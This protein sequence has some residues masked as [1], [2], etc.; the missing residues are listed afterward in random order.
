MP[1]M[2]WTPLTTALPGQGSV[3]VATRLV[4]ARHRHIPTVLQSTQTLWSRLAASE[5]LLGYSLNGDL[6]RRTLHTMSVWRDAAAVQTFVASEPHTAIVARTRPWIACS[7]FLSWT[8]RGEQ[9]PITWPQIREC[10][11]HHDNRS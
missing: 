5:G 1:T 6:A 4:L 3:V 7:T 8:V 10:F 2:P 9:L 11:Q